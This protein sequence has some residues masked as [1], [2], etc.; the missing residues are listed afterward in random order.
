MRRHEGVAGTGDTR[1]QHLWRGLGE[2]AVLRGH[3]RGAAAIGDKRAMRAARDQR[4]GRRLGGLEGRV[5]E[6]AGFLE[7]DVERR[8]REYRKVWGS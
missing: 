5:A 4:T 2:A 3:G 8:R 6:Q 1:D 7:I